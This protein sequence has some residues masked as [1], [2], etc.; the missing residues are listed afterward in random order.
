MSLVSVGSDLVDFA[1]THYSELFIDY[2]RKSERI[3]PKLPRLSEADFALFF[4][5]AEV[6]KLD[7]GGF[8]LKSK[9]KN[10]N[11]F[12]IQSK[13]FSV[14]HEATIVAT[15]GPLDFFGELSIIDPSHLV[16]VDVI[17]EED[18][19]ELLALSKSEIAKITSHDPSLATKFYVQIAMDLAIK[20]KGKLKA[21]FSENLK[22]WT[23]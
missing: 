15:L 23:F 6:W 2:T 11:Y 5:K 22:L 7:Q 3:I 8:A 14:R 9:S 13:N 16:S 10:E 1:V 12:R 20:L 19:A 18:G 17:C 21:C 4:A